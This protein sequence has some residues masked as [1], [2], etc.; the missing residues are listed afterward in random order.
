MCHVVNNAMRFMTV[1]YPMPIIVVPMENIYTDKSEDIPSFLLIISRCLLPVFSVCVRVP[2]CVLCILFV[3]TVSLC[4][5]HVA[6]AHA[7]P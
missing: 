3:Y 4:L 6:G 5:F 1:L 7:G 2:L